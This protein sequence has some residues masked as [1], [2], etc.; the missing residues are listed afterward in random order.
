[1]AKIY[2][3]T[4]E[5]AFLSTLIA[6]FVGVFIAYFTSRRSFFLRSAILSTT[7]IPVCVPPLLI[8]LGYVGFWGIN[9]SANRFLS[10][11]FNKPL[12]FLYSTAGVVIAQGFYNFPLVTGIVTKAWTQLPQENENAA[13]MLGASEKRI[14]FTITL[15]RLRGAIAAA[16]IPV[17][18]YCFFSFMMVLLF[19]PAGKSTIEVEIYHSIR[20][21]LNVKNGIGLALLETITALVVTFIYSF[22][23]KKSQNT[24]D[25]IG[26]IPVKKG[27]IRG[28]ETILF[29]FLMILIILFFFCPLFSILKESFVK[30]IRGDRKYSLENYKNLFNSD[31]F[32][33]A[34]ITSLRIGIFTGFFCCLIAFLWAVFVKMSSYQ[35]NPILQT[36]PLLPM[37]I[38]SVVL[39][40]VF[41]LIFHRG[42]SVLL[43]FMQ[44]LLFWPLAYRQI[45]NGIN[46]ISA[47]TEKAAK[48]LSKNKVDLILRFYLPSC[49]SLLISSFF[50]CFAISIGDATLPLVLSIP[51]FNTIALYTYRLASTYKFNQACSLG[52]LMIFLCLVCNKSE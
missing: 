17:F 45:Q 16:C 21:T 1:M 35:D 44:V 29:V 20:S 43:V 46:R 4:L 8:A 26:Y 24:S 33:L 47:D 25:G 3:Y 27:K 37:A 28:K 41:G 42:N 11:F 22:I 40:W 13:R 14:L 36:I 30:V 6:A 5:I 10:L 34:L 23:I 38:S 18:I 50:Y 32:W 19:S 2:F 31:S 48:L 51:K 39:A 15:P 9:G 7:A 12:T 49:K 52:I